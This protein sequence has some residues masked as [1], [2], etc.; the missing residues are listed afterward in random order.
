MNSDNGTQQSIGLRLILLLLDSV[1]LLITASAIVIVFVVA[2]F[3]L[4]ERSHLLPHWDIFW[5]FFIF[6]PFVAAWDHAG[7]YLL[8]TV[9]ICEAGRVLLKPEIKRA[10]I[11]AAGSVVVCLVAYLWILMARRFNIH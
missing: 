4:L 8:G 7:L 9:T 2:P 11:A 3:D 5:L 6:V 10:K 1:G